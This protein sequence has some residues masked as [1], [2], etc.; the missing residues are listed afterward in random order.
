M[1]LDRREI[2]KNQLSIR[3]CDECSPSFKLQWPR[4]VAAETDTVNL[5]VA[6]FVVCITLHLWVIMLKYDANNKTEQY[7]T[8]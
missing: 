4:R 8:I 2:S 6:R 5:E 7:G 3:M 1:N